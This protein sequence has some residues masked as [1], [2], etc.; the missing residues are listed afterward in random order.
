MGLNSLRPAAAQLASPELDRPPLIV[1]GVRSILSMGSAGV[2]RS[3]SEP[4]GNF[5][6]FTAGGGGET[7]QDSADQARQK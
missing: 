2:A 6:L 5:E 1:S 4:V 3:L 7:L